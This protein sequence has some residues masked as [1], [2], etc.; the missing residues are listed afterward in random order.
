M[1]S[2]RLQE[3]SLKKVMTRTDSRTRPRNFK[4]TKTTILLFTFKE[5]KVKVKLLLKYSSTLKS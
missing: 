2:F 1:T 5:L 3:T 4:F